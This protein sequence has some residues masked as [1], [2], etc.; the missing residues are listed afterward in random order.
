MARYGNNHGSTRVHEHYRTTASG[1]QARVRSHIRKIQWKQAGAAWAGAGVSGLT[2]LGMFL[3]FGFALLG[4][5]FLILT[6]VLGAVAMI[7]SGEAS[8]KKRRMIAKARKATGRQR[9][10]SRSRKRP[11]SS[12]RR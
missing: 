12:R 10:A 4:T 3:Q 6:L 9:T 2:C 7:L 1:K 8:K 5:I 11:T